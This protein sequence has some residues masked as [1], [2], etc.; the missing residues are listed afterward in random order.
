MRLVI[1][2]N[3]CLC[4]WDFSKTV[5]TLEWSFIVSRKCAAYLKLLSS[6]RRSRWPRGLRRKSSA[7]HLLRLWVWIPRGH[8]CLYVLSAMCFQVEVFALCDEL[9]THPEESYWLWCVVAC[10]LET[11]WMRRPWPPGG[12][13]R[14]KQTYSSIQNTN[15]QC[16]YG[17]IVVSCQLSVYFI[18]SHVEKWT[19]KSRVN[20]CFE[21][22]FCSQ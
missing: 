18:L 12:H 5:Y 15:Q 4:V 9:F 3:Q 10:D 22:N 11:L 7:A 2:L 20:R 1:K 21:S 13:S 6:I 8:G 17:G 19:Y 14:Q 16:K